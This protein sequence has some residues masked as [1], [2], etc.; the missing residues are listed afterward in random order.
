[1]VAAAALPGCHWDSFFDPSVVGRWEETPTVVPILDRIHAIEGP[2]EVYVE[3]TEVETDD[4]VPEL[5]EYRIG[6]GDTLAISIRNFTISGVVDT[7]ERRVDSRGYVALPQV[8]SAYIDGMTLEQAN[9]AILDAVRPVTGDTDVDVLVLGEQ[10]RTFSMTGVVG[11]QGPYFVP[12]AD[13]RLMDAIAAAGGLFT[14]SVDYVYVIRQVA[15][16]DEA[17]G[18]TGGRPATTPPATGPGGTRPSGENVIDVIDDLLDPAGSQPPSG[19]PGVMAPSRSASAAPVSP[20]TPALPIALIENAQPGGQGGSQP[21]VSAPPSSS[22]QWLYLDGEWVLVSR[23]GGATGA[24]GARQLFTQR[25][26]RI[27]VKP[28]L[29][30]DARYNIVIRPNDIVRVPPP[31]QG[32]IFLAGKVARPGTFGLAPRLTLTR[33]IFASGGLAPDAVPERTDLVRMV[34]PAE[35]ATMRLNLRAIVEGTQ[36]DIFLKENDVINVGTNFWAYPL[37]VLRGGFRFSY[38]FGFLLDR[39]FGNDLFGA[40]PGTFR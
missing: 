4:L 22:G 37:A 20:A 21:A 28:L 23:E 40:P 24:D 36:P 10:Q 25:V 7:L 5:T 17:T 1:M 9:V 19:S 2:E 13:Y 35:Q 33:A 32:N 18:R 26:I 38:G 30:G 34:G 11:G 14:E 39:N 16:T 3:Y 15:L 8:G 27:P 31:P 29:A 12:Y 6:P